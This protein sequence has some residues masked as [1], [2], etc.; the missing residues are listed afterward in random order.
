MY[1]DSKGYIWAGTEDGVSRYDGYS[2]KHFGKDD[3]LTDND[4]F[5]IKEDKKGRLWFLTYTGEPTVYDHGKILTPYNSHFLKDIRPGSIAT[6]FVENKDTIVYVTYKR[7]YV[8][9]NDNLVSV[10]NSSSIKNANERNFFL[11]GFI[12]DNQIFYIS[13]I[14]IHNIR[15]KLFTPFTTNNAIFD[16]VATKMLVKNNLLVLAWGHAF[17]IYNI[18]KKAFVKYKLLPELNLIDITESENPDIVWLLTNKG[19]FDLKLSTGEFTRNDA[20]NIPAPASL[21]RDNEGNLWAGSISHGLYFSPNNNIAQYPYQTATKTV[22]AYSLAVYKGK[23]FAGYTNG[24]FIICSSKKANE[25]KSHVPIL[26]TNTK[27][28]GFTAGT[29]GIW[30]AAGNRLVQYDSSSRKIKQIATTAKAT[31]EDGYGN[32]YIAHSVN[33]TKVELHKIP[34]NTIDAET[35]QQASSL[36]FDG[37]VNSILCLGKD[38][39]Y[40]AALNGIHLMVN[41]RVLPHHFS[42]QRVFQTCATKVIRSKYGIAFSTSGEGM[43]LLTKDSTYIINKT[44]GLQSNSCNSVFAQGDTIWVATTTGLSRIIIHKKNKELLFTFKNYTEANG[45]PSNKINDVIVLNDTVWTATENGVCYFNKDQRDYT[46]PPPAVIIE[47]VLANGKNIAFSRPFELQHKSNNIQIKFTGISYYSKGMLQYM[48]KLEGAD[49]G[50]HYT[51]LREVQY[52]SLAPGKYRF[53]LMSANADDLWNTQPIEIRFNIIPPY[54]QTWWFKLIILLMVVSTIFSIIRYRFVQQRQKLSL[55]N[56][57]LQ[58]QKENAEY[59]K[60]LVE[61]EQ[62][63]LRLQM[64]P[65]FIFNA[66]TAA[67]GLYAAGKTTEA[68]EYLRRF[69]RM[70]R[71]IFEVSSMPLVPLA[72]ELELVTDYIELSIS[73]LSYTIRYTI[74]CRVDKDTIAISPLVLQPLVENALV[75]GLFPLKKEGSLCITVYSEENKIVYTI[76]DNGKGI[77]LPVI[78][79]NKPTGLSVTRQRIALLNKSVDIL[80][81]FKIENVG[82]THNHHSGTRITFTTS[83]ISI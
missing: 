39:V 46:F 6:G 14:G 83:I 53:L 73:K 77:H 52:P 32:L 12:R 2:F 4:V 11:N 42:Q 9:K 3:G 8:L 62:Q 68:K 21:I 76:E 5:Q 48:Y 31:A 54:W 56:K 74:D 57:A 43:V 72:R 24:E 36:Y 82:N 47:Q 79:K 35:L 49:D 71:S 27:V 44:M 33:V 45:L 10:I 55:I 78:N 16:A 7:V 67:Q 64:N 59:E 15:N 20:F 28:Y 17:S 60:Q 65:H 25:K 38:S 23:I 29:N 18:Q 63:A 30:V 37:R 75:H 51:S 41:N 61:L 22:S 26:P 70:L 1:Q 81:T 13:N 34:S 69:S 50:W 19:I 80:D 66:I 58:L 40:L